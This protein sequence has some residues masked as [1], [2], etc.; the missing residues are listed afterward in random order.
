[1]KGRRKD[2]DLLTPSSSQGKMVKAKEKLERKG[3]KH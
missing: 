3:T 1:V 2:V